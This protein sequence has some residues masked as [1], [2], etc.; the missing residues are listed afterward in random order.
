MA[1]KQRR[2]WRFRGA[3]A[4]VPLLGLIL[5]LRL[6]W[7]SDEDP[8]M[9]LPME[10]LEACTQGNIEVIQTGLDKNPQWVNG[11]S[12]QGETCLHLAGITG[13]SEVT[14]YILDKGGDPN[15]RTTFQQGQ[16]M[17]PLSWNVYGG[18]VETARVLLEH[19]ADVNLDVDWLGSMHHDAATPLDLVLDLL[20]HDEEK[21]KDPR[22]EKYLQMKALLEEFGAQ[23]YSDLQSASEL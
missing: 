9:I 8:S 12:P 5:N 3:A 14:R 13:Q 16:R 15:I 17:H 20:P 2:R 21:Q 7:A 19:G 6:T 23:T 1:A 4:A 11:R 22:F 10:Y 18:H